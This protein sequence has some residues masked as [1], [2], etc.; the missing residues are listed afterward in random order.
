M[1]NLIL[2]VIGLL[3]AAAAAV[4][5]MNYGGDYFVESRDSGEAGTMESALSNVLS[6]YVLY[7]MRNMKAP[8]NLNELTQAGDLQPVLEEIP[9]FSGEGQFSNSWSTLT[10]N[11]VAYPAVTIEGL[12]MEVCAAMTERNGGPRDG[13]VP[14]APIGDIGCYFANPGYTAYRILPFSSGPSG[15]STPPIAT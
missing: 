5:T 14:I 15:G 4:V 7:D 9:L 1:T 12:D 13:T 11:S 3:L 10:V 2:T 8:A 6:A